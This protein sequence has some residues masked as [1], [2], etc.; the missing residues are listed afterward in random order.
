MLGLSALTLVSSRIGS[1]L[2]SIIKENLQSL[3]KFDGVSTESNQLKS[4]NS[5]STSSDATFFTGTCIDLD[6][7]N[8]YVKSPAGYN[9]PTKVRSIVL[10]FKPRANNVPIINLGMDGSYSPMNIRWFMG[11]VSTD[12]LPGVSRYFNGAPVSGQMGSGNWIR[13]A[14][15]FSSDV[16]LGLTTVG[17]IYFGLRQINNTSEYADA[18]FADVQFY[19]EALS[20]SD[21]SLIHI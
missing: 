20:S 19:D 1:V 7:T 11:G 8:A 16:Y 12:N 2:K 14:L 17:N 3:F 18:Q 5:I 4:A 6:G 21:L 10:W 15:V 9:M 13:V